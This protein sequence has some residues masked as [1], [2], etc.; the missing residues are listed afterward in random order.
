LG[1]AD[2]RSKLID[3]AIRAGGGDATLPDDN[4]RTLCG[5]REG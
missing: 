1:E 2:T 5:G 4:R 3:P